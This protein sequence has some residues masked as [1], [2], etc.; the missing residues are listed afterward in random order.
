MFVE[1]GFAKKFSTMRLSIEQGR[2]SLGRA[3]TPIRSTMQ[4]CL[5]GDKN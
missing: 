5:V 3:I 4:I 1:A 2:F